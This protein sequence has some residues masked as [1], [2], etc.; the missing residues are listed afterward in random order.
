MAEK[1]GKKLTEQQIKLIEAIVGKGDRA[2]V[3][4]SKEGIRVFHIR[5]AEAK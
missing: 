1:D 5:R 2:E 4:P 3:I